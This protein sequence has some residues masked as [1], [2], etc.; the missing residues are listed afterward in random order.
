MPAKISEKASQPIGS[1]K[2]YWMKREIVLALH[3]DI[4]R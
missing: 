3:P 4:A 2:H 1:E